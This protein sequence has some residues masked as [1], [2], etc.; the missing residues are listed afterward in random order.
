M[1]GFTG[2]LKLLKRNSRCRAL[3]KP[4]RGAALHRLRCNAQQ[5]EQRLSLA[6]DVW[7]GA[8]SS[9]WSD[10]GNW[11]LGYAP[12]A[13]DT[14]EFTSG[15]AATTVNV[16]VPCSIAALA[17]DG[18][19]G[20]TINVNN[21]L[22]MSGNFQLASG[23]FGGTGAVTISGGASQWSGGTIEVGA[24][25]FAVQNGG[26]FTLAGGSNLTLD[27][28]GTLTNGGTIDDSSSAALIIQSGATLAN[29][30]GAA[31]DFVADGSIAQGNGQ[32]VFYNAGV[33]EKTGGAGASVVASQF[34]N[35]GGTIDAESG[36]ISLATA[37][38][39]TIG[40]TFDAG[41]GGST[42]A[43]IDLTGGNTVNYT[44]TLSGSGSGTVELADGR[45]A[46]GAGGATFNFMG[47]LFQWTGGTI[48]VTSGGTLTNATSGVINVAGTADVELD[49]QGTLANFGKVVD[50]NTASFDITRL[51]GLIN[52]PR[53]TFNFTSDGSVT[54]DALRDVFTNYGLMEKTGGSGVTTLDG[55]F[56]L[57]G[58]TLDAE[59]GTIAVEFVAGF[60]TGGAFDAGLN[61]STTAAIDF[62]G[63]LTTTF[64][65]TYT[66]AGSG[67]VSLANGTIA[68]VG[69]GATFSFPGNLFQWSG[70]A[71]DVNDANLTNANTINF[72][73]GN[74]ACGNG[75]R[76]GHAHLINLKS[77]IQTNSSTFTIASNATFQ[78][79]G[80]YVVA[81][82][83]GI[84][85]GTFVNSGTLQK[86]QGNGTSYI[87]SA[88]NNTGS[89]RVA[90]GTIDVG[91]PVVQVSGSTLTAG[92]WI[93]DGTLARATLTVGSNSIQTLAPKAAAVL[94]GANAH[95]TNLALSSVQG[96][97]SLM[98]GQ[99]YSTAGSLGL[100][101]KLTLGPGSTLS[102]GG[103]FTLTPG[104][105][106]AVQAQVVGS[107]FMV[108]TIAT[109]TTGTTG[110][111]SLAGRFSFAMVGNGKPALHSTFA[112]LTGSSP[113]NGAFLGLPEGATIS[114]AGM[115]FRVSYL[116]GA[117]TLTRMA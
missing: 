10:A 18:S 5:L 41:L 105:T 67:T 40:G 48:D 34:D 43:T 31:F 14:A 7:T 56:S 111:I 53:A 57:A 102:L 89:V 27:G 97:L 49:G 8:V 92:S 25:G 42:T 65:G 35:I 2:L 61:G 94:A 59:S 110:T 99:T 85:G 30:S 64:M 22:A 55:P 112:I 19:W 96:S 32:G 80:A 100:S 101:G 116:G 26:S 90:S 28:H 4:R 81:G 38:G 83:G 60:S 20:G 3:R 115:T 71:I 13:G 68:I 93:V 86:T 103:T 39:T 46:V 9:N 45:F 47:T 82:D 16:D 104:G 6:G 54:A 66:G 50:S 23:V 15:A 29:V 11:S 63:G 106:L 12:A 70:G 69:G 84:A 37:G 109:G 76:S 78:N 73:S 88:L 21:P 91:G 17:I 44:G 75:G 74:L 87:A 58:G 72:T 79:Q 108:G 107:T 52:E 114:A 95:W 117:V 77:F 24:G 98:A 113:I 36:T 51:A 62:T 1:M 33:L